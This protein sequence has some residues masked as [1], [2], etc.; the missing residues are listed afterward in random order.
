MEAD[1]A[2]S[3][4]VLTEDQ[5]KQ[6]HEILQGADALYTGMSSLQSM[7]LNIQQRN[8]DNQLKA[9]LL[10]QETYDQKKRELARKQAIADKNA[11]L[12]KAIINVAAAVATA[13]GGGP[14]LGQILAG[15]TAALGAV[16]IGVIASTPIPA[17][18]RGT[19][20]APKGFKWVGEQGAELIYDDGGYP[21]ITN[22]ESKVLSGNPYSKEARAIMKKY[23]IPQL[24]TGLFGNENM[25]LNNGYIE[26]ANGKRSSGIDYDKLARTLAKHLE[27]GDVVAAIRSHQ[28]SDQHGVLILA[29]ELNKAMKQPKRGNYA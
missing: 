9:G 29:N 18:A 15:I 5:V 22:R 1:A 21:I 7:Q 8:L 13:L 27:G 10:S 20:E 28:K 6:F 26:T 16:E 19:K 17:F 25:V 3:A 2:T 4:H 11:A 23:D 24:H 12:F 14:V